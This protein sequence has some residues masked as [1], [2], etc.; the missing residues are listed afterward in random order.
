MNVVEPLL[1]AARSPLAGY[2]KFVESMGEYPGGN[3]SYLYSLDTFDLAV[4]GF[5]F[6]ILLLLAVY[7]AYR[8]RIVYQFWRYAKH[9]PT[10]A[11]RY[12][13][14]DLPFVTVQLPLFN[15]MYVAERIIDACAALDYPADR[16]E[17]QVL[18]DSTDET[19]AVVAKRVADYCAL[20]LRIVHVHRT[21]RTGFKAGALEAGLRVAKGDL[22]AIFDADFVPRP[23][24]LRRMVDHFTD[25]RVGMVQM[26]WGHI[27]REYSLL[28]R[29]QA[30]MLDGHFV[31]EQAARNRSGAFFNFNGTAG[32][33]RR[34]AIGWSGGWQHDTL[35]EDTDLSFRAQLCGWKFV[36]L[37]DDDVPSELPVEMNAF[38]AQQRRWAKGLIEVAIKLM[39]RVWRD[40]RLSLA[41]R[42]ELFFRLTGNIAAPLIIALAALNLPVL[43][44]RY[45]QGLFHLLVLDAP[46]L[47]FSTVS[48][49]LFYLS[50]QVYLSPKSW[51]SQLKYLPVVMALGIGLSFSNA[52]AVLEALFGIKTSFVRT[53]KYRI[54]SSGDRSWFKKKYKRAK[55]VLPALELLFAGYFLFLIAFA[56][57]SGIFGTIPFFLLFFFGYAYTGAL[58]LF[59]GVFRSFIA[60]RK[61]RRA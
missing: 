21:D 54:E 52:Q 45:N 9:A 20:G 1:F 10:P 42:L 5:Y 30:I 7:G 4:I 61:E 32:M 50:G 41:Q 36:Y 24:C 46:I 56:A 11:G 40:P 14:A 17:I 49:A 37:L 39:P 55:G 3:I 47:L 16:L 29:V 13:E 8:L 59:G 38:K 35:T 23:D 33:W 53:P 19:T 6:A 26:R 15:E 25:D 28:T 60:A 44:V 31:V 22:V 43:I 58:S 48:V 18:D 27:N 57:L 12:D 34:E 2:E 51:R